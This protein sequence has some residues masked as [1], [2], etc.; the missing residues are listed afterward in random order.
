MI[1]FLFGL[2]YP[3]FSGDDAAVKI[4]VVKIILTVKVDSNLKAMVFGHRFNKNE[5]HV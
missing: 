3:E 2:V 5:I 4:L 1:V